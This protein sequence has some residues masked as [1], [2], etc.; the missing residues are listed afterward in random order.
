MTFHPDKEAS[1][2][3]VDKER[4]S[5]GWGITRYILQSALGHDAAK[6]CQYLRDD[7]LYFRISVD[8]KS[9]SK[10]WLAQCIQ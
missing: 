4:S 6:N 9:S 10:A 8:A 2:R 5:R 1:K 7:C 3:V